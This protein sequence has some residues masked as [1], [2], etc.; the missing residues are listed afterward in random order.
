MPVTCPGCGKPHLHR[1]VLTRL[2][3]TEQWPEDALKGGIAVGAT[4]LVDLDTTEKGVLTHESGVEFIGTMVMAMRENSVDGDPW[5]Y[6]LLDMLK[7]H[8]D[9]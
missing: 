4:Y 9:A 5:G 1:A 2:R 7:I 3:P 8:G 6:M